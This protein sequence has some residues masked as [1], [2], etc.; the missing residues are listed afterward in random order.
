MYQT[1]NIVDVML[2]AILQISKKVGNNHNIAY[3]RTTK[4]LFC[5]GLH[6]LSI[7]PSCDSIHS[8]K[9]GLHSKQSIS[10]SIRD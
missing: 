10:A 7:A 1:A 4:E 8:S 2:S 6:R 9:V 5:A 3:Q